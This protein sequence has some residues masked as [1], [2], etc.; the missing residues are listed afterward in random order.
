MNN[1]KAKEDE[2]PQTSWLHLRA[3]LIK[4]DTAVTVCGKAIAT[5]WRDPHEKGVKHCPRCE[6]ALEAQWTQR[7]IYEQFH[8]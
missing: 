6:A 1:K 4:N 8:A 3:S 5:G 2:E 7:G